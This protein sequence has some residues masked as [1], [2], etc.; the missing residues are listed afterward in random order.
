MNSEAKNFQKVAD[1]FEEKVVQVSRVS[2]KRVGGSKISFSALV[3]V[4]DKK[5]QVGVGLGKAPSVS[6]AVSKGAAYAKK[7]LIKVPLRGATIPHEVKVKRGAAR[8]LIKPAPIGSG[9]IAGGA[10]R[11]VVELAGIKDISSK[12]LG[13]GNKASNV[14]ATL[15][16]LRQLRSID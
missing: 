9:L 2:K 8:I 5:G 4:G 1:G 7:H 13:T 16:A 11:V 15:E 6:V 12:V 14:Y 3:V 10:V